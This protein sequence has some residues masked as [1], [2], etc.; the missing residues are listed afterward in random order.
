[1][2]KLKEALAVALL[3]GNMLPSIGGP[4][5][6]AQIT[7]KEK[8]SARVP[9]YW[10]TIT[11]ER[12]RLLNLDY[13]IHSEHPLNFSYLVRVDKG[14]A[15]DVNVTGGGDINDPFNPKRY[16]RET[17]C[18]PILKI[19][20]YKIFLAGND[21][22]IGRG[23][24]TTHAI[25][26]FESYHDYT[27]YHYFARQ[28]IVDRL[29]NFGNAPKC[30]AIP[31][32]EVEMVIYPE[33]YNGKLHT[34]VLTMDNY[35]T[36][37]VKKTG[38]AN[39]DYG[40]RVFGVGQVNTRQGKYLVTFYSNDGNIG[41]YE[42]V[43]IQRNDGLRCRVDRLLEK[44]LQ[45]VTDDGEED[46][47]LIKL[48]QISDPKTGKYTIINDVMY[49]SLM[50]LK[51]DTVNNNAIKFISGDHN[52]LYFIDEEGIH[53]AVGEYDDNGDLIGY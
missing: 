11:T 21:G 13:D 7:V 52:A 31:V 53:E 43:V 26:G 24:G 6:S 47:I 15:I 22:N 45:F 37:W 25:S 8:V 35:D 20:E 32:K 14:H 50:T 3:A 48:I 42:V 34:G 10:E 1:M 16:Y 46:S 12:K 49:D 39:T 38:L 5:A 4:T 36:S 30:P 19:N 9:S 2:I 41:N 28:D 44:T 17:F 51:D 33:T 27:E 40:T 18:E 23:I 29:L